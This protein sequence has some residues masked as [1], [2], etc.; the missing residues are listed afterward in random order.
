V[1]YLSLSALLLAW[2]P[3]L[4]QALLGAE[5]FNPLGARKA[6]RPKPAR[7]ADAE[8]PGPA[9]T[10]SAAEGDAPA[11]DESGTAGAEAPAAGPAG[12]AASGAV[13]TERAAGAS[14]GRRRLSF[15][16]QASLGRRIY[17]IEVCVCLSACVRSAEWGGG[18]HALRR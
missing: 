12:V 8:A 1:H 16:R 17:W 18:A 3:A 2:H 9:S 7:E 6:Q 4:P 14:G 11:T 15:G 13:R 10:G 5:I